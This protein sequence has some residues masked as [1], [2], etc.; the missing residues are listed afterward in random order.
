MGLFG[1]Q[2]AVPPTVIINPGRPD[3]RRLL[4][5]NALA[6]QQ[7][8]VILTETGGGGGFGSPWERDPERVRADVVD[9]YVTQEAA[10]RDYG[11][12]LTDDLAIDEARTKARR[13]EMRQFGVTL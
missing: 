9:G 11:V 10:A 13:A 1:G 5:V 4:K 8:D 12:V 3:E 7:G 2:G 6:L